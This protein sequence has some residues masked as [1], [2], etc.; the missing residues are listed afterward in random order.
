MLQQAE[1]FTDYVQIDIMD[2]QFVPSHSISWEQIIGIPR[3]IGW[4]A[5]LMVNQPETQLENFKKAGADKII[6][7]YEAT[8][9]PGQVISL[10]RKLMLKSGLAVN[11]ETTIPEILPYTDEVDSV[12]FLSVHPGFYGAQF[13]PE[14]LQKIKALRQA[15]PGINIG[16]DGGIKESNIVEI[17]ESGVDE[18]CVGSA[19]FMRPQPGESYRN[20]LARVQQNK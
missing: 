1:A 9:V 19:I 2:G 5:H 18:I 13:I 3:K 4:E 10:A 8:S 12:L 14:V 20:L 6:F 16:I 11:P 17:A 15:K 7:H